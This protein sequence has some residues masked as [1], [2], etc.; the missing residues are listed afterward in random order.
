MIRKSGNRFSDKIM[1]KRKN[2][3]R[4]M[5]M[6][7]LAFGTAAFFAGAAVYVNVAE[8]PA[9]LWLD[10]RALLTEWK[11]SYER[12]AMMQASL[13]IVSGVLGIIAFFITKDWRWLL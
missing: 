9:R 7:Q 2:G 11:P 1:L 6:G 3:E 12:G 8:Q 13:A 4:L 5:L 10:D